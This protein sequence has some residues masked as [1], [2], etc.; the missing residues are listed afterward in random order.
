MLRISCVAA[1]V[2]LSATVLSAQSLYTLSPGGPGSSTV[3]QI[4]GPPGG[5]CGYPVGPVL[6]AFP[7]FVPFGCPTVGAVVVPPIGL[8]G[9]VA[10]SSVTDM[11]WATSGPLITGYTPAGAPVVSFPVPPPLGLLTG[12]GM[13]SAAGVLWMTDGVLVGACIP[14]A[15]GCPP[16]PLLLAPP[17]PTPSPGLLTDIEWDPSSGTLFGCDAAGF[18]T[19]MT[20]AG[21]IGPFGIFPVPPACAPLLAP[22]LTGLAVDTGTPSVLGVPLTL[23]VTDG[24]SLHRILPGGAPSLPTFYAP[25]PCAPVIGGPT[26]GLCSALHGITYGVACSSAGLPFPTMSF[27]GNSSTPGALT[28]TLGSGPPGGST[29]LLIDTAALCPAL[30]FKGCP[31]YTLPVFVFGPFPIPAA[32]TVSLPFALPP[33][34]PVGAEAFAQWICKPVGPGWKLSPGGEFTIGLP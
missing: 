25:F 6:S 31:L 13:N 23:T 11:V 18:I 9:D 5:P 26:A 27:A 30:A 20:V 28:I 12:L 16:P 19:N 1:A 15:G 8:L 32:G 4:T 33:G 34:L 2:L 7:T 3:L 14:P 22:P 21:A 17:F 29:W 10:H 24:F